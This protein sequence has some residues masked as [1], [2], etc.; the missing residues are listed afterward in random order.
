MNELTDT[1]L[2]RKMEI[3]DSGA[4]GLEALVG[5]LNDPNITGAVV[6]PEA[7]AGTKAVRPVQGVPT[8]NTVMTSDD[9]VTQSP[10]PPVAAAAPSSVSTQ[11][12][13][14]TGR[15]KRGKDFCAAQSGS[16]VVGF[17]EP[18]YA[19]ATYFF[20]VPV[21]AHEGK[22]LPGCRE[23]LQAIGQVGRGVITPEY[24]MSL[25][26][27]AFVQ[28]VRSLGTMNTPGFCSS[29]DWKD[30]G[31]DT[32]I[33]IKSCLLR[34]N[35]L[36]TESPNVRVGVTNCRF[37]DEYKA[38]TADGWQ[39]WHVMC[40]AKTHEDRLA[41]AGIKPNSPALQNVTEHMASRLDAQVTK[42]ISEQPRGPMLHV[43]WNDNTPPPSPRLYTV[44]Q[45][46]QQLAINDIPAEL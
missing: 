36:L 16:K 44:N 40:S 19:L 17:A 39:P 37:I 13:F 7:R 32:D 27:A 25:G 20:G 28:M 22:D 12:I 41:R 5:L 31:L 6:P 15:L 10:V 33:W 26:R 35:A 3:T 14:F 8:P 45:F 42:K 38:L 30:Y 1:K 11:K 9:T 23:L 18:M 29:V 46:L 43:I 21:S 2:K 4:A 34:A 24:P